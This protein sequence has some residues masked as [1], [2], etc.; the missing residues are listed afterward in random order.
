MS[1]PNPAGAA[2]REARTYFRSVASI[3][4]SQHTRRRLAHSRQG[5]GNK[6][7]SHSLFQ[8]EKVATVNLGSK[9]VRQSD[10]HFLVGLESVEV[11]ASIDDARLIV[12][13]ILL[14]I[15]ILFCLKMLGKTL[16]WMT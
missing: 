10:H 2:R 9:V 8:R 7:T 1:I 5:G 4:G 13:F 12:T 15:I 14:Q 3:R 16:N 11:N 6:V